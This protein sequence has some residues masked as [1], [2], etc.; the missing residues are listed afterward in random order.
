[1]LTL[2]F[3]LKT[4]KSCINTCKIDSYMF[5]F[6]RMERIMDMTVKVQYGRGQFIIVNHNIKNI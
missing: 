3:L 6:I 5:S 2:F 1:M 4:P